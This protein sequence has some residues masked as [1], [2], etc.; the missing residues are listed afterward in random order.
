MK[1]RLVQFD[2][3]SS[4]RAQALGDRP[5][6]LSLWVR[7]MKTYNLILRKAR[8]AISSECTLPQ[9]D[10]LAQLA[11][12]KDGLTF[13]E[14]SERLLVSAGNLT[15]IVDRLEKERLAYR[16]VPANDRRSFRIRLTAKGRLRARQ[17]I[18]RH[19]RDIQGILSALSRRDQIQLRELLAR[20]NR[21][22][23]EKMNPSNGQPKG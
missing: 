11:R 4:V 23:D 21:L 19:A 8:R 5:L 2:P 18:D 15:G 16:E 3:E 7:L 17:L 22:L 9:F 12:A 1:N 13:R 14:L 10:V 6:A 20:A